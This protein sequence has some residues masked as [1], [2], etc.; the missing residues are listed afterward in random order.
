MTQNGGRRPHPLAAAI[1]R[2]NDHLSRDLGGG[3]RL[4]KTSW[5]IN[6]QKGGT[7]PFVAALMLYYRNDSA[8]A[9]VYLALHGSYGLCWLLKHL[10]FP[11]R[12]W[13]QRITVGAAVATALLLAAYWSFPYLLISDVLGPRPEPAPALLGGAVALHTLGVV[14]MMTADCQKYFLLRTRPGLID[15]GLFARVRHPNYLGEMMLYSA[16]ALIVGHWIPW[17]VLLFVWSTLFSTNILLKEASMS[18]HPT[19]DAYRARAG[20]LLPKPR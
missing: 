12:S 14:L 9:W 18:R 7:A 2:F 6:L 4:L 8:A 3:P 13:D 17:A 16:Y 5:V 15:D 10:A 1:G 11:D 20:M 19:W